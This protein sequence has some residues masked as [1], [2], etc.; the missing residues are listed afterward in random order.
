MEYTILSSK[1]FHLYTQPTIDKARQLIIDLKL[2]DV[3]I[4]KKYQT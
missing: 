1:G 3:K 2:K 4:I